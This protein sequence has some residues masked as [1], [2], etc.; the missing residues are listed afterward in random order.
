MMM[1]GVKVGDLVRVSAKIHQEGIPVN[2]MG[3]VLRHDGVRLDNFTLNECDVWLIQ[4]TNGV[5]MKFHNMHLE[6]MREA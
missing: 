1:K 2:R 6:I 3:I 5:V 4:L